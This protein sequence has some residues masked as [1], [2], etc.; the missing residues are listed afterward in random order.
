MDD[1]IEY[2]QKKIERV[3]P[4]SGKSGGTGAT[5]LRFD[6]SDNELEDYL[7]ITIQAIMHCMNRS[8]TQGLCKLTQVS[9]T[10][11]QRCLSAMG[12]NDAP[13]D[14]KVR[15][16]DLFIEALYALKYVNVYRD[17]SFS[18]YNKD[19]PYVVHLETRWTEIADYPLV[20]T[21]KD[22]RGTAFEPPP[23]PNR[24]VLK[25]DRLE[26]DEWEALKESQH[27]NAVHKLQNVAMRINLPVLDA[28]RKN[29]NLFINDGPIIIPSKGNKKKMDDAY[30]S[31]RM[32]ENRAKDKESPEVLRKK[33][34][35]VQEALDWNEKLVALKAQSKK[36][37]FNYTMQKAELLATEPEFYQTIELDY[38]GRFYYVESFFNFQGTDAARGLLEFAKGKPITDEGRRW[39]A[40]HTAAS[41]NQ[42]YHIDEIPDWCE[43]DYRSYLEEEGLENI[44]VDKMTLNDRANWTE[45]NLD[46]I[47]DCT[48]AGAIRMEAEKPVVF[49]ACCVEW[50]KYLADPT[51]HVSHLPIQI[52]GSNNGWQHLGAMSKDSI[53]GSLVGLVPS[54][55]QK[56]FYVATAKEL[57]TLMPDWFAEKEMPMKHIRKGISKRGSMTRAYSAGEKTMS[58]NMYADCYQEEFTE[59]Y[60]ITV[61]DCNKLS[62]NLITAI[63]KVCP[64]PLETM[65]FLQKLAAY[66]I[67]TFKIF[68]N[69]KAADTKYRALKKRIKD[70]KYKRDKTDDELQDLSDCII[71]L[72]SYETRLIEGN[73]SKD[74]RWTT[75]SGFFVVYENYMQRSI[76]CKG[77]INGVGRINHVAYEKTDIPNIKG[78]MSGISPNFVHSMDASHMAIIIDNWDGDFAA[79]HDAFATHCSDVDDLVY[80]T[81]E[82]FIKI[83]EEDNFYDYIENTLL[84]SSDGLTVEQPERG[85]LD[86]KSVRNSDYFFA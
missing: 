56:D 23:Y 61:E 40:I 18:E 35:Y 41:Y 16:G 83:Y 15:L 22:L 75:P 20:K 36:T 71:A 5:I 66:E 28:L 76:K 11:G 37:A 82:T 79:V 46:W 84:S 86:I 9:T 60:G 51:G 34:K 4:M 30:Y 58:T 14:Q 44:S 69:G 29:R 73:G 52:D 50:T 65:T 62:H 13:F 38:R 72:D 25:R 67:G 45:N 3:S 21:K 70:L 19:A 53:T 24:R 80:M 32:A 26:K 63:N 81:K 48:A 7:S 68:K 10:I 77:T 55:I 49:Y 85:D 57:I 31:W 12:D 64:G 47:I 33:Q 1:I 2:L 17:P 27:I 78:Y 42:S 43:A 6:K 59:T 54:D 74:I 8:D 39:L